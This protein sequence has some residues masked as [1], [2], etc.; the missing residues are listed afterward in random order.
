MA[1]PN[2]QADLGH[3]LSARPVAAQAAQATGRNL[4]GVAA[5]ARSVNVATAM[6]LARA[7]S[8]LAAVLAAAMMAG[9]W[10]VL[11]RRDASREQAETN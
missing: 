6:G 2:T 7:V 1:V 10:Q 9:R 5:A 4:A 11:I 3:R 8:L